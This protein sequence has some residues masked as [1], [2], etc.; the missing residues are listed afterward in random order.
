MMNKKYLTGSYERT[1]DLRKK[2]GMDV[3]S[4]AVG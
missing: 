4:N 3:A 2:N 1:A